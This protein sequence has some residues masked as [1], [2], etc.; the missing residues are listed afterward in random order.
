MNRNDTRNPLPPVAL[1]IAS[2]LLV[3][4]AALG[5][6]KIFVDNGAVLPILASAL[7]STALAVSLRRL[8][9]PLALSALA[10]AA[11]L[12]V[13]VT[14]YAIPESA[15]LG[16]VPTLDSPDQLSALADQLV[17]DFREQQSPVVSTVPFVTTAMASVWVMA[18][19]TDWGAVRLRL[20]FEPVLPGALIF[21]FAAALG[22]DGSPVLT[23]L[24]FAAVIGIWSVTQRTVTMNEANEWLNRER[25][26][27]LQ[28][29]RQTGSVTVVAALIAG[30]LFW[31]LLPGAE[32]EEIVSIGDQG[33]PT[34]KVVSPYVKLEQRLVEQSNTNLFTVTSPRPAYWRLAGLDTFNDNIW[35]VSA[36][37]SPESGRLPGA[38][39][40]ASERDEIQQRISVQSLS[41][42]WLPAAYAPTEIV[43]A[44]A[45]VTWN[46]ES[47]SLTV[48]N[49]IPTSDGVE[50]TLI[51]SVPVF[52]SASLNGAPATIRPD[53]AETFLDL[54]ALP[55]IVTD[56]ARQVTAGA[57]TR[58][59][60][61]LALQTFFRNFNYSTDLSP[62]SGDPIVQFL[63]EREGFCQQFSGTF[64]LMARA[65]GAPS[66][67]AIGFTWG[68]PLRTTADGETV[69]QVTGRHAHAWPEVWF[70]GLGWV[71][72][73]PTP[74]RGAPAGS[75]YLT[76]PAQQDSPVQPDNPF[77]PLTT[78]TAPANPGQ[79][80]NPAQPEFEDFIPDPG[81]G[82][83][84][85]L[86]NSSALVSI[87]TSRWTLGALLAL[88]LFG[89]YAFLTVWLPA[90][91]RGSRRS[92]AKS[93]AQSV[94]VSW[95]ETCETLEA[96]LALQ[97]EPH[98]TRHEFA[99]RLATDRRIPD[100]EVLDL[101][102]LA[103]RARYH[104][105]QLDANDEVAARSMRDGLEAAATKS[106][107]RKELWR[108]RLHPRRILKLTDRPLATNTTVERPTAVTTTNGD[109]PEPDQRDEVLVA[110]SAT[111]SPS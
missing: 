27:G 66:R 39:L 31:P 67:V 28:A 103:T 47:G 60:Q 74:G 6:T 8:R 10:N 106:L 33:D 102:Q 110:T 86:G 54:P 37:F 87:I 14:W 24:V 93:P 9:V 99:G 80:P 65:L 38:D 30:A 12:L 63:N 23:A 41:A 58:Y 49:E 48:S 107:S 56:T 26:R 92:K 75:E 76:V 95:A 18:F 96:M 32:A 29:L 3:P 64:A 46:A 91:R 13:L 61:M 53:I 2:A 97:R 82:G 89:L 94:E 55:P 62:R 84:A 101:A 109:H 100:G 36:N 68:D 81:L 34:R 16:F 15:W 59:E 11:G 22:G 98:E 17:L 51:S 25:K 104:P 1:E 70:E 83:D 7:A 69:Y 73:E 5:F 44:T 88:A 4:A 20:A 111:D 108:R 43:D 21:V 85:G 50:Y 40:D 45:N 79:T 52:S 72:F 77:A 35:Q 105:T 78:T 90:R 71:A 42:I 19:L 57:S